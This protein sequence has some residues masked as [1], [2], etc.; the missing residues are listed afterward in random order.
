[1]NPGNRIHRRSPAKLP[2][3]QTVSGTAGDDQM[4]AID[5]SLRQYCLDH[6]AAIMSVTP[7]ATDPFPHF[8]VRGFFPQ[9]VYDSL[10]RLL[11][12]I[13][14]YEPFAYEKHH[15]ASG[16][17]NRWRFEFSNASLE[18]LDPRRQSFWRTVRSVAGSAEL[19][20]L[21]FEKLA[22]GL[23]FRYGIDPGRAV[24]FPGFALPELFH[25]T[26]G[27][28]IKPHPDTRRKVVTMQIALPRNDSQRELGTEFYRRSLNPLTLT[29]AP[30]GFVIA[31][32]MDFRPNTAYAFS[33][34]NTFRLKSWHGR[35]TIPAG[36]GGR[37]S[38]LN[39]WYEKAADANTE[40]I[41][42]NRWLQAARSARP[43]APES[44]DS[45]AIAP[46]CLSR[47]IASTGLVGSRTSPAA[48]TSASS[49]R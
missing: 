7:L 13:A 47:S 34:L 16:E 26:A 25:E 49:S 30:R 19:K 41:D 45:M 35:S 2:D 9:D 11:P 37:N 15:S 14:L 4:I 38:I 32:T 12:R 39:I 23:A 31:R 42:E 46:P 17:S 10:L 29:R 5:L 24:D 36:V 33:V 6:L 3:S 44:V 27:Y 20:R 40:L 18:R 43:I 21:A 1:M 8:V 48:S 28:T 22:P